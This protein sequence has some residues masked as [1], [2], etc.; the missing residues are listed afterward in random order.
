[1]KKYKI[2]MDKLHWTEEGEEN[3]ISRVKANT[4]QSQP[5][6]RN[7]SVTKYI[8]VAILICLLSVTAYATGILQSA[9][10]VLAPILGG[11]PVQTEIIANIG[12]PIGVSDTS[13]GITI[14]AD[15]II[16]DSQNI[17]VVYSIAN[18]DGTPFTLPDGVEPQAMFFSSEDG[19]AAITGGGY[20]S[21]K[22]IDSNSH[23]GTL[24]IVEMLSFRE[25]FPVGKNVTAKFANLSYFNNDGEIVLLSDGNWKLRYELNFENVGLTIPVEK[26]FTRDGLTYKVNEVMISPIAI[27]ANYT[28]NAVHT[29]SNSESGKRSEQDEAEV[30]KFLDC[31]ELIITKLDGTTIDLTK[32]SGGGLSTE[33]GVTSVFKGTV[34][35]EIVSLN[36]VASVTVGDIVIDVN[37]P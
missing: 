19:G 16:G 12:R 28:V 13:D 18:A 10:D 11:T 37:I 25:S 35:D 4:V 33:N 17:C 20:G 15:A 31:I 7:I 24:Q 2:E 26:Q 5:I 23:D 14:S 22:I 27:R 9:V 32:Y 36:E 34:L 6:K 1:M 8:L 3:L 30:Y 21:T 29:W